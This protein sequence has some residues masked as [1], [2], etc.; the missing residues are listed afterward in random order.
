MTR[1]PHTKFE[2]NQPSRLWD[3]E[4]RCAR[5]HVQRY[6]IR[7]RWKPV[8][9][10]AAPSALWDGRAGAAPRIFARGGKPVPGASISDGASWKVP[11]SEASSKSFAICKLSCMGPLK[12]NR[13]GVGTHFIK[14]WHR[15]RRPNHVSPT[16]LLPG[17]NPIGCKA[18]SNEV[19]KAERERWRGLIP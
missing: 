2:Y 16:G 15:G 17:L 11:F 18:V 1:N 5:A 4:A 6:P 10:G 8:W 14:N 7:V 3:I 12:T 13:W 19:H 9:L